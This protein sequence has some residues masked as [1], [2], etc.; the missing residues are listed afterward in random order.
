M[1][2]V[3]NTKPALAWRYPIRTPARVRITRP[4]TPGRATAASAATETASGRSL[5]ACRRTTAHPSEWRHWALAVPSL[6][7]MT[8]DLPGSSRRKWLPYSPRALQSRCCRPWH[9]R[10]TGKWSDQPQ[11]RR[12]RRTSG[13]RQPSTVEP[14]NPLST[15][16]TPAMPNKKEEVGLQLRQRDDRTG[17]DVS[18]SEPAR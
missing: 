1:P 18:M 11:L 2:A 4:P 12:H 17:T 14:R 6:A 15:G 3:R 5:T 16:S 7:A 8:L 10:D 9:A 13:R